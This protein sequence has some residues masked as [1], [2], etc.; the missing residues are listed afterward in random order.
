MRTQ[1]AISR[2]LWWLV[3]IAAAGLTPVVQAQ[4][5]NR[6]LPPP[7]DIDPPAT[8]SPEPTSQPAQTEP[9]V[10]EPLTEREFFGL[11]QQVQKRG[12]TQGDIAGALDERGI[13]FEA[14]DALIE[15]ARKAGAQSFLVGALLRAEERRKRA[16]YADET[17]PPPGQRPVLKPAPTESEPDQP[18]DSEAAEQELLSRLSLL[19]QTRYHVLKSV[20]D[21]PNFIVRQ[22]IRRLKNKGGGWYE[23][24]VLGTEITYEQGE[25]EKVN[26]L[27]I[28]NVPTSKTFASVGGSTSIGEFSS[29]LLAPFVPQSKTDF[30]EAGR[31]NYRGRDCAIFDFS[32]AQENSNYSIE[33]VG[34]DGQRQQIISAYDGRMW[35]DRASKRVVRIEQ[36]AVRMPRDF[37][38][39]QAE[40]AVEYDWTEIGEKRYWLP[41]T[42]ETLIGSD[43][44]D[45]YSRNVIKFYDYRKFEADVKILD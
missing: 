38:F 20:D 5:G 33:G 18:F 37:L 27:T 39:S 15:R 28:N 13:A 40:T 35:I 8:A 1:N 45:Y 41:I 16:R 9:T 29:R 32:V 4:S 43:R 36:S 30:K 31:E 26:L 21:F 2:N 44:Y 14:T 24:D 12:V 34:P 7:R 11:L 22:N 10:T 3:L 19:E 23:D 17:T 25:G 42:A 6:R